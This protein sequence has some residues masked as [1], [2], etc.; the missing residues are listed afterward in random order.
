M[1]SPLDTTKAKKKTVPMDP[2]LRAQRAIDTAMVKLDLDDRAKA[3]VL[4]AASRRYSERAL[5]S[6]AN[7]IR[8]NATVG[9]NV[10]RL[11]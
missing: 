9:Q 11:G 5:E 8:D 10:T 6:N 3:R 1:T 2:E 7:A 4:D